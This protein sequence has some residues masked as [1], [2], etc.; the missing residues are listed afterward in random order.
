M[1]ETIRHRLPL[2][3]AGQAQKEVTHNE[4]LLAIDRQLQPSVLSRSL[5]DPPTTPVAGA[6]YIVPPG[7]TGIWAGQQDSLAFFDGFGWIYTRPA[8]G[9]LVWV[10]DEAAFTIFDS[11]WST[12]GWPAAALHIAGRTVLGATPASIAAPVGGA[13]VDAEARMVIAA[14]AAALR[15]QGI[16][17]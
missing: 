6:S 12:G 7:A 13:V 4:A 9:F 15:A 16:I 5:L 10:V 1:S 11:G 3:A 2:L 14:I 17:L 8:V